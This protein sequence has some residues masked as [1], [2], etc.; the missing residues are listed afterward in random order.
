MKHLKSLLILLLV[1]A[2]SQ[3]A[4]AQAPDPWVS[5]PLDGEK[6]AVQ[7]PKKHEKKT[8]EFS[9][10]QF[11]LDGRTYTATSRGVDYSVW[12]LVDKGDPDP[13]LAANWD[14]L[15][16]CADLVWESLLKPRR[17]EIPKDSKLETRMSYE[18]ELTGINRLPG[19]E[20]SIMMDGKLGLTRFY[21]FDRQIYILI[22][23]NQDA[24][25]AAAQRFINSFGVK[26]PALPRAATA[27]TSGAG[28]QLLPPSATVATGGGVGP[29]LAGG[30]GP[31]R[32]GNMG[33][34]DRI[35]P[36]SPAPTSAGTDYNRIFSGKDVTAKARILSKPEPQ[37]TES[38]RKYSVTGTVVLRA[39][40][41]RSG[42]VTQ[43][44]A[45]SGLPH[46]LTI[47][48]IAAARNIKFIPATK[49]GHPV[50]MWFQLEYNYNLY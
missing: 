25:S 21:V 32:G 37:Y 9:F 10:E 11:K 42:Q 8:Q 33:T 4:L 23:L 20:Y 46:G 7:M 47:R 18:G 26:K 1:C 15:D 34:G 38:A 5:V 44:R 41:S 17:D 49:D 27:A 48:A 30:V 13:R 12:S 31:G 24:N 28:P 29:G 14:Y 35:L 39:V 22:V 6:L 50:S 40:F 45:V 36:G 2:W 19:R 16:A 43:I 3:T